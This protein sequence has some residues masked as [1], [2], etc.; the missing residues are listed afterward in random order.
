MIRYVFMFVWMRLFGCS[1]VRMCMF[2]G[3]WWPS[4]GHLFAARDCLV[5]MPGLSVKTYRDNQTVA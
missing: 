1:F 5:S 2:V 4:T 3:P